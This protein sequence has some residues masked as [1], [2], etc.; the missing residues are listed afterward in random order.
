MLTILGTLVA[1]AMDGVVTATLDTVATMVGASASM[2]G[3]S[4]TMVGVLAGISGVLAGTSGLLAGIS[5]VLA[6]TSGVLAAG[7]GVLALTS[8][9]LAAV[10]G[11]MALASGV[12]AVVLGMLV[13]MLGTVTLLLDPVAA[14][15]SAVVGLA[16][17]LETILVYVSIDI[18]ARLRRMF[19]FRLPYRLLRGGIGRMSLLRQSS[20]RE[21]PVQHSSSLVFEPLAYRLTLDTHD[22]E[23]SCLYQRR[24]MVIR[25][26]P[27]CRV[28]R[29]PSKTTLTW[30]GPTL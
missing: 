11:A 9:V 18:G 5:S 1:V 10:S 30:E 27:G 2:I 29:R 16:F 17:C 19:C 23:I 22:R 25:C 26:C 6:L 24:D 13:V 14:V 8:G 21:F 28:P 12:L 15:L 4:A 20:E 7:S 3:M